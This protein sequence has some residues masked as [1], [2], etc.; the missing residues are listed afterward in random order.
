[1]MFRTT[2]ICKAVTACR[3]PLAARLT[4]QGQCQNC[5][6][7]SVIIHWMDGM[8][9]HGRSGE[10]T[11]ECTAAAHRQQCVQQRQGQ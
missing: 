4:K 2:A 1:M 9:E 8:Q 10:G 6:Q 5:M 7:S 3:S 11:P